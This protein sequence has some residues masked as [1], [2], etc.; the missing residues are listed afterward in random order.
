MEK[1][2][3]KSPE[4]LFEAQDLIPRLVKEFGYTEAKALVMANKLVKL[5]A[6]LKVAFWDWWQTG[7]LD[8]SVEVLGYTLERV[9]DEFGLKPVPAFSTLSWIR[10]EP[11]RALEALKRGRDRAM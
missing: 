5:E 4:T 7:T 10:R 9:M 3:N 2:M 1:P 11:E 6:D 8:S